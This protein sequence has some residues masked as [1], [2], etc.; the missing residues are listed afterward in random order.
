MKSSRVD[1]EWISGEER[2]HRLKMTAMKPSGS[3]RPNCFQG[4]ETPSGVLEKPQNRTPGAPN[5]SPFRFG[6]VVLYSFV[7]KAG[8]RVGFRS[9]V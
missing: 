9:P 3:L 8:A 2:R 1:A 5:I 6:Q 4:H 7:P